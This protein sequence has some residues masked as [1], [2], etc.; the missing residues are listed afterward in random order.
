[1]LIPT[2]SHIIQQ[3]KGYITKQ[4]GKSIWQKSFYD[5][6]IR[7]ETDYQMIWRYIDENPIRW[8]EDELYTI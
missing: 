3:F 1:M 2:I 4:T 6:V 8:E 7:D 5:H